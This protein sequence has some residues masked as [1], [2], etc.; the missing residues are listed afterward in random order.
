LHRKRLNAIFFPLSSSFRQFAT[1]QQQQKE[2]SNQAQKFLVKGSAI[3]QRSQHSGG[4]EQ[5]KQAKQ[6]QKEK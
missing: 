4:C 1:A 5:L 2:K 6:Q 3:Q